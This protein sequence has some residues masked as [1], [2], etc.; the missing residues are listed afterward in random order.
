[1]S[2]AKADWQAY[3]ACRSYDLAVFYPSRG[4]GFSQ[5]L[6]TCARCQVVDNCRTDNDSREPVD[7]N[8]MFGVFG[9][10]TPNER[11]MRRFVVSNVA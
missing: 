7:P 4:D 5:A 2:A 11:F 10:E 9:G 1:M 3:A 8:R 6:R